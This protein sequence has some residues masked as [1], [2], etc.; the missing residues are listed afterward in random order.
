[1]K[2]SRKNR[3]DKTN[4]NKIICSREENILTPILTP[5]PGP[6]SNYREFRLTKKVGF[7]SDPE[8]IPKGPIQTTTTTTTTKKQINSFS[9]PTPSHTQNSRIQNSKIP[10]IVLAYVASKIHSTL[11]PPAPSPTHPHERQDTDVAIINKRVYSGVRLFCWTNR[12]LLLEISH[13]EDLLNINSIY[14][15]QQEDG[16]K[17]W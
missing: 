10:Q 14:R 3:A 9:P 1:M 17:D 15:L 11:H 2:H 12:H 7:E 5:D 6:L 16:L 4:K 13:L 8:K